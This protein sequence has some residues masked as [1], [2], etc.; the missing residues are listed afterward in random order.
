MVAAILGVGQAVND[1]AR[2]RVAAGL[3]KIPREAPCQ[4]IEGKRS[5]LYAS[6]TTLSLS[7]MIRIGICSIHLLKD[8]RLVTVTHPLTSHLPR[9]MV[10]LMEIRPGTHF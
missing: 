10:M 3:V 7:K 5:T 8:W 4:S 2:S 1:S 6:G 9:K